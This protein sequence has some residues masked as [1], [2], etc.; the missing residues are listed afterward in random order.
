MK[1][2]EYGKEA[3]H[4]FAARLIS[5][6]KELHRTLKKMNLHTFKTAVKPKKDKKEKYLSNR[7]LFTRLIILVK[8]DRVKL[9]EVHTY[10]RGPASYPLASSDGFLAKTPKSV[11]VDLVQSNW[12]VEEKVVGAMPN[13]DVIIDAM[14][15]IHSFL[16]SRLPKTFMEFTACILTQVTKMGLRFNVFKV[17]IALDIHPV[18]S[19]NALEHARRLGHNIQKVSSPLHTII[20]SEQQLPNQWKDFLC[21]DPN[22]EELSVYFYREVR[23]VVNFFLIYSLRMELLVTLLYCSGKTV[24]VPKLY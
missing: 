17:D 5:D 1:T 13:C 23:K 22:K 12:P 6:P 24:Q 8:Q 21:H 4:H 11:I 14:C 19:I 10:S 20:S 18:I 16:R 2:Y 15:L 3:E 7:K 9:Q